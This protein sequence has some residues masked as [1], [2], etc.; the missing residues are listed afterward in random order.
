MTDNIG[1]STY[2]HDLNIIDW[3]RLK[4]MDSTQLLG[5][6]LVGQLIHFFFFK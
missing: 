4:F 3:T 6:G 2:N 5:P 1:L